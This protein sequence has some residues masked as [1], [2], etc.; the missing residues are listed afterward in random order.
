MIACMDQVHYF[1]YRCVRH[2]SL[3]KYTHDA[4]LHAHGPCFICTHVDHEIELVIIIIHSVSPLAAVS[5]FHIYDP[6]HACFTNLVT[7]IAIM[8]WVDTARVTTI[9]SATTIETTRQRA[10]AMRQVVGIWMP[11]WC[12][13]DC[14]TRHFREE[15]CHSHV[16]LTSRSASRSQPAELP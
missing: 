7:Q 15:A 6:T 12:F 14:L 8:I 4:S 1:N 9:V 10:H 11:S 2:A 3:H 16:V 5:N 13:V